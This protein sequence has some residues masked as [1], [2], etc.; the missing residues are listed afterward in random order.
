MDPS[1]YALEY[2]I[3]FVCPQEFKNGQVFAV[4]GEEK[5]AKE[6]PV[7]VYEYKRPTVE[8]VGEQELKI[9]RIPI[10]LFVDGFG[11][12]FTGVVYVQNR[13]ALFV[14]FRAGMG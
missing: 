6:Q 2:L 8:S 9:F 12:L 11:Q 14:Y 7:F 3:L 10:E 4:N 13:L 1:F 5:H